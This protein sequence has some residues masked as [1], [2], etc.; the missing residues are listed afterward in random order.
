MTF[1]DSLKYTPAKL[2][3]GTSGLRG[4]VSDMTD[5]ECYINTLGFIEFL[6]TY[7]KQNINTIYSRRSTRI[8]SANYGSCGTS[9]Y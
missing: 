8:Y 3:F 7:E 5:L 1:V 4:L 2:T 6:N 9:S